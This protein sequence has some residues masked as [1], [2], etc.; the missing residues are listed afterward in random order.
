MTAT[1]A[2]TR[3]ICSR[4]RSDPRIGRGAALLGLLLWLPCGT[5]GAREVPENP[6]AQAGPTA[7]NGVGLENSVHSTF[8]CTDCHAGVT[9]FSRPES[10]PKV[11]CASCHTDAAAEFAVSIHSLSKSGDSPGC[12]DCH[13]THDIRAM[14][15]SASMVAPRH[16]PYTCSR[17]H[18]NPRIVEKNHIPVRDP[19][20]A[21][22]GSVHGWLTLTEGSEAAVCS[23]CHGSHG[24]LPANDSASSVNRKNIPRTCGTCHAAVAAEFESS[25][26]HEAV[27]RGVDDAPDCNDCHSEHGIQRAR[28][29][30]SPT[31]PQN[32]AVETCGRCHASTRLQQK[33]GFPADRLSS[34]QDSYHGLALKSG[35]LVAANCASCHGVHNILPS[36]DPRSMIAPANLEKT[37][38]SCHGEVTAN[39]ASGPVHLTEDQSPSAINRI[40]KNIYVWM[41]V[42]V[43]GGMV[44]HNGVDFLR[45]SREILKRR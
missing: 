26:H 29:P 24:I 4:T 37:C 6:Y 10:L 32:M 31:A 28:S 8:E 9:D 22:A 1:R 33:F 21:Y 20:K 5:A 12:T 44:L 3:S 38:G 42:L 16:E 23:D 25:I 34:F 39:F 27:M 40:V 17:C 18:S 14:A 11:V 2:M 7:A 43:I 41:I 35:N 45:R 36:T 30:S 15:D 19:L 13:G